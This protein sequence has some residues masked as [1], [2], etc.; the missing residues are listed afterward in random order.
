M[1]RARALVILLLLLIAPWAATYS[2]W[3]DS[4]LDNRVEMEGSTST[5]FSQEG[6][7]SSPPADVSTWRVGDQWVYAA[8]FD[9]AQMIAEGGVNANVGLLTADSTTTVT[10]ITEMTIEN[11][12]TIVYKVRSGANFQQNG[13]SLDGY[14]GDLTID[15]QLDEIWRASDL[16]L[17]QRDMTLAVDFEAFGF[18]HIDVADIT[19]ASEYAPPNEAYDFP[20]RLGERWASDYTSDVRWTGQS[21]YFTLPADQISSSRDNYEVTNTGNPVDSIGQ[22]ISYS[23]CTDSIEITQYNNKGEVEGFAWYCPNVRSYAWMNAYSDPGLTIDFRLKTYQPAASTGVVSNSNPGLRTKDVEVELLFPLTALNASQEAWVNVTDSSGQPQ[24][25]ESVELIFE[26]DGLV[27]SGMTA[28][29]GSAW[30]TFD[31]GYETDPSQTTFD[32]A[33]HGIIGRIVGTNIAGAAS[34]T[35]DDNLVALDLVAMVDRITI[36]RNRSGEVRA[37]NDISGFNVLPGDAL[38]FELPVMNRGILTTI[39]TTIEVDKPDGTAETFQVPALGTY[40][41]Y[42]AS[43]TWTVPTEM[44]I[45][46][47]LLNYSVDP[48]LINSNDADPSNNYASIGVFVGRL[49]EVVVTNLQPVLTNTNLSLNASTSFDEDGG[50]VFCRYYVEYEVTEERRWRWEDA[51][52]CIANLSWIDDG[53]FEVFIHLTDEEQDKV[54]ISYNITVLNRHSTVN[55]LSSVYETQV[56]S[57]VVMNIFAND[58]DSEDPW[59]GMVD[60]HWP[61][62]NCQ[63]GYYT[64]T[65]TTTANTEG[66]HTFT[67]IGT[68][69]DGAQTEANWDVLFTNVAPHDVE[70]T[71]WDEAGQQLMPDQQGTWHVNEDDKVWLRSTATDSLDDLP[72]LNWR[73]RPDIEN[74]TWFIQDEG[75]TSAIEIA[76]TRSGRNILQLEVVDDDSQSSGII[77]AWI[78]VDN[79]IPVIEELPA[80]LPLAEGQALQMS[81]EF[82]DTESDM[83]SI[84]ACWDIDPSHDSDG[85]GS[86]NDDCDIVG[87][88]LVWSWQ[89]AG[90]HLI[91]FHV[92]DDDGGRGS[93]MS[94]ITVINQPPRAIISF[95][96]EIVAGQ[97]AAFNGNGTFDAPTD[98]PY[99]TYLWDMD[100]SVDSDGDGDKANDADQVG[101]SIT[102]TF[103][104]EGTYS[105]SLRVFDEDVSRPGVTTMDIVVQG[106]TGGLFGELLDDALGE[107]T[108][109]IVLGLASILALLAIVVVGRKIAKKPKDDSE[110]WNQMNDPQSEAALSALG[111]VDS[112]GKIPLL[113]NDNPVYETHQTTSITGST[114]NPGSAPPDY[115]FAASQLA[116][117]TSVNEDSGI[118]PLQGSQSSTPSNP[119]IPAQGLPDGWTI[120]QWNHYGSQWLLEQQNDSFS[121]AETDLPQVTDELDL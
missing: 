10:E 64:R 74:T 23:A 47:V 11:Q 100:L 108:N 117:T 113:G 5:L 53:E 60:I 115:A 32:W 107:N 110:L 81:A 6:R 31:S 84:V 13:V 69:D 112:A 14:N 68:D 83:A 91:I 106:S 20:L 26:Q 52:G 101:Q 70:I 76:W 104:R 50:E 48:Q 102:H 93:I 96:E 119:A 105:I 35:L 37:L 114:D 54:I 36:E 56:Y 29:N 77:E 51:P 71:L 82:Y 92:T 98:L 15:Y 45:G 79:V 43:F 109:P 62:A 44:T 30:F 89:L 86:A 17:I 12:S 58:S 67:A 120:D 7:T 19:I 116:L 27:M 61:D 73:W 9:V 65:C 34:M 1:V 49:P 8:T 87:D 3:T 41:E 24:T 55:I 118:T 63:E 2:E 95:P 59:P 99:L 57:N 85:A 75:D 72:S 88:T 42:R 39:P 94:N 103:A 16:G 25:G 18:I 4:T 38:S 66:V 121:T 28:M 90:T 40:E 111:L 97:K 22:T 80:I 21:D 33:S 46:D 78:Q